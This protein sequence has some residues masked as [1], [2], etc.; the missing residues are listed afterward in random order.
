MRGGWGQR[1]RKGEGRRQRRAREERAA[2]SE[3]QC[4]WERGKTHTKR[5]AKAA[6]A[7][8]ELEAVPCSRLQAGGP[9]TLVGQLDT[10]DQQVIHLAAR[11]REWKP[12]KAGERER[13]R[14]SCRHNF[15]AQS[16]RPPSNR[17]RPVSSNAHTNQGVLL[18][19]PLD[20]SHKSLHVT[21]ACQGTGGRESVIFCHGR[22]SGL[23]APATRAGPRPG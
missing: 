6:A 11:G 9:T 14:D 20:L 12:G 8:V 15:P 19:Q 7:T 21:N 13:E 17:A 2:R 3:G 10:I 16:K 18:L 5:E 1:G 23:D 22:M 4:E